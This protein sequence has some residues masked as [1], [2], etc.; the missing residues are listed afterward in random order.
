MAAAK[1]ASWTIYSTEIDRPI[2]LRDFDLGTEILNDGANQSFVD[3]LEFASR[4]QSKKLPVKAFPFSISID[5]SGSIPKDAALVMG[6]G[7]C[8][9]IENIGPPVDQVSR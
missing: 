4:K 7:F 1:K 8:S 6:D 2:D 3:W 9:Y 5:V